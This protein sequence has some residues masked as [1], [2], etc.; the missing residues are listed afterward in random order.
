MVKKYL[1]LTLF[2]LYFNIKILFSSDLCYE[3]KQL[4]YTDTSWTVIG[5]SRI[6]KQTFL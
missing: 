6:V 1:I 4:N 3:E 5:G 2:I